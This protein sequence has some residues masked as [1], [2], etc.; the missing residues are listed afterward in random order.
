MHSGSMYGAALH[1]ANLEGLPSAAVTGRWGTNHRP[2]LS[3]WCLKHTLQKHSEY[4]KSTWEKSPDRNK[5]NM[6]AAIK[7]RVSK[8]SVYPTP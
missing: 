4:Q 7:A 2:L 5:K 1:S 6:G 3:I 8:R